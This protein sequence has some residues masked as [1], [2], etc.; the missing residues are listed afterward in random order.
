MKRLGRILRPAMVM[1]AAV[2]LAAINVSSAAAVTPPPLVIYNSS[3]QPLP[4]NLPSVGAEAYAFNELGDEVTF[5]GTARTLDTVKVTL[6][7]W[8]CEHGHW[9]TNDCVTTP[10]DKF[11][12]PITLNIYNASVAGPNSTVVPGSL[13]TTVTKTFAVPYRPTAN[14]NKCNQTNSSLGKW[15]SSKTATCYN[16][17]AVNIT[18][19]YKSLGLTLPNDVVIGVAYNTS[20]YGYSPIGESPACY[21]SDAGCPYDSLNIALGPV[22]T[23]GSKPYPDTLFQNTSY[24]GN[25][26]DA[27]PALGVFNLD[28]PTNP[29]W[30]GYVPAI[31]VIAH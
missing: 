4:G 7:S 3:V 12:V 21:T 17:K 6:S 18:F 20:H 23:V 16:G 19:N 2:S 14:L 1:I 11:S 25:L 30:T 15:Y 13:I 28:S 9:N 29:C 26:C 27:T 24:A 10:G 8:G 31:Q 5:A 22:V